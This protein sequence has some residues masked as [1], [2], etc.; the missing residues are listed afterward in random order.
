[1][2]GSDFRKRVGES[3]HCT[4]E[5]TEGQSG[6]VTCLG[7][8]SAGPELAHVCSSI[9]SCSQGK[10]PREGRRKGMR[11]V[12]TLAQCLFLLSSVFQN[13]REDLDIFLHVCLG[14]FE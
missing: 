3:S 12:G 6:A 5:D 9:Q 11:A 1:M 10:V 13:C 7:A 14:T 8:H 4:D 2:A